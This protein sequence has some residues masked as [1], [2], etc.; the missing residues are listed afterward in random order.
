VILQFSCPSLFS[1]LFLLLCGQ[2]QGFSLW[3][4]DFLSRRWKWDWM[5]D[6]DC[7]D[8]VGIADVKAGDAVVD[9]V[10]R[11]VW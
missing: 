6:V 1:E 11:L 3:F 4:A 7:D 2:L 8:R 10:V 5:L 9:V